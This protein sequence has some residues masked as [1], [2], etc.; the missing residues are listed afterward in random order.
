MQNSPGVSTVT[1][2][3]L[4][5]TR[6]QARNRDRCSSQTPGVRRIGT[7]LASCGAGGM[8]LL[9]GSEEGRRRVGRAGGRSQNIGEGHE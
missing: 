1:T 3:A 4:A 8:E 6:E 9:R 2:H 7:S 5:A